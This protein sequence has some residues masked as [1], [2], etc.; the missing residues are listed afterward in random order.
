[1]TSSAVE[2]QSRMIIVRLA[3]RTDP[4]EKIDGPRLDLTCDLCWTQSPRVPDKHNWDCD[5]RPGDD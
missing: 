4:L 1:M 5:A 3:W 2:D